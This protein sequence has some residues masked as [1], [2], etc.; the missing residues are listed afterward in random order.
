[1]KLYP[2][3]WSIMS[4]LDLYNEGSQMSESRENEV[5]LQGAIAGRRRYRGEALF[6]SIYADAQ[7]LHA[8]G[9]LAVLRGNLTLLR[10]VGIVTLR[11]QAKDTQSPGISYHSF[12]PIICGLKAS[13]V[14]IPW[15]P[16]GPIPC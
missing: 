14:S 12:S 8:S 10:D 2:Q 5:F 3:I 6:S 9:G 4:T 15:C 1:M 13:R 7:E 11:S 16:T